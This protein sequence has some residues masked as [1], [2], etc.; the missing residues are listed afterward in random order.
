MI[1]GKLDRPIS[2]KFQTFATDSYG[3][4]VVSA[5]QTQTIFANFNF[6][7]GNTK[8]DG[9][10]LT[11]T[12]KIECMIRYRTNIGTSRLY[13]ISIGNQDYTIKSVREIG[14]K[15]YLILSLEKQNFDTAL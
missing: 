6:K 4:E 14:R 2:L 8:I 10:N 7:S 13:V 1:F 11:T 5:T 12:E 3:E 9:D 15:N